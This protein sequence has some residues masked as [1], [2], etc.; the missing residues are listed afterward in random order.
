M[1]KKAESKKE[2][3]RVWIELEKPCTK[4][5]GDAR[6]A[7]V[8][9][10]LRRLGLEVGRVWWSEHEA[11]YCFGDAMGYIVLSDHGHW[12]NLDYFGRVDAAAPPYEDMWRDDAEAFR[13]LQGKAVDCGWGDHPDGTVTHDRMGMKHPSWV[14]AISACIEVASEA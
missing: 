8:S 2:Q 13:A 9:A 7:L 3:N 4:E 10:M 5:Q 11:R 1:A 12:F 6:A 14:D